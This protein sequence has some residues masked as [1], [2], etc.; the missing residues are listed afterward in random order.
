MPSSIQHIINQIESCLSGTVDASQLSNLSSAYKNLE[1]GN[2][3]SVATINDL[4]DPSLNTGRLIYILDSGSYYYSDGVE[5]TDD[6]STIAV[7]E[8]YG[9]GRNIN[10]QIG[11]GTT[12]FHCS[13]VQ[14]TTSSTNWCQVKSGY[15]SLALKTN[16]TLWAWGGNYSGGIGDGTTISRSSPVQEVTSSTN[17]CQVS[18]GL[19]I[20][21]E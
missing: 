13:P 4:P 10:G 8:L 17:W 18:G 1:D 16:N 19:A 20:K 9:W 14:E 12:I 11:D 15:H 5:W 21:V 2:V 7:S 3:N 6:Y